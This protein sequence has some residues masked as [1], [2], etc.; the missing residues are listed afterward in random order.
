MKAA[1]NPPHDEVDNEVITWVLAG[2]AVLS[3]L[4]LAYVVIAMPGMDHGSGSD[5]GTISEIGSD[6]PAT[7]KAGAAAFERLLADPVAVVINVHLPYE[8][9]L[10]GTDA[11]VA[12]DAILGASALPVDRSVTAPLY[13][14]TGR[15]CASAGTSHVEAGYTN[16]TAPA[17]GS[18]AW[19]ASGRSISSAAR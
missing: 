10:A 3:A 7:R 19:Q 14:K 5:M 2:I 9:E 12:Y 17:G 18:D 6:S 1:G 15:V 8:G 4:A 11:G 16:V 13:C